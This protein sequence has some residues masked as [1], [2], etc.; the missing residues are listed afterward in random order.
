MAVPL[1][2]HALRVIV[3]LLD[4]TV[5][6]LVAHALSPVAMALQI[7]VALRASVLP[8]MVAALAI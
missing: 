2:P 7:L 4:F 6:P 1:T 8:S 5:G 3:E